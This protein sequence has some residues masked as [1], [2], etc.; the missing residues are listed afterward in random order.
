ME[1][2]DDS[3]L[4]NDPDLEGFKEIPPPHSPS[5]RS[6]NHNVTRYRRIFPAEKGLNPLI[7]VAQRHLQ[8]SIT[9]VGEK[10]S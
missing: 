2:W 8:Y 3:L 6:A 7:H 1:L 10:L 4:I 5:L 9:V